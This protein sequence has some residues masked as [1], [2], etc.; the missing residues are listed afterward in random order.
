MLVWARALARSQ[1][2]VTHLALT[3]GLAAAG[4]F[5]SV[6]SDALVPAMLGLTVALIGLSSVRT[7]FYSIPATFLSRE[8]AAGGLAFINAVGSLGGLFGPYMVGWLKDVTG[9]FHAGLIGMGGMLVLATV[10]TLVLK[11]IIKEA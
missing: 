5:G 6:A 9:S 3:C 4:F 2:Y 7:C 1:R 11:T 8:A 10:L